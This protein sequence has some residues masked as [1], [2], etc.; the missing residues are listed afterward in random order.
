MNL[1]NFGEGLNHICDVSRLNSDSVIIDAGCNVGVFVET[2]RIHI[3]PKCEMKV[4]GI[5]PSK[6]N[7][8]FI[9]NKNLQNFTLLNSA[10]VGRGDVENVTM[11]EFIGELKAD[12][13]NRYH[14]W[15]NIYGHHKEKLNGR[16]VHINEY[17]VS[18][19]TIEDL[20][21][22]FDIK[23]IDYLKIDIEGAEYEVF[24]NLS[25][26]AADKIMQI[27]LEEHDLSK[28]QQ[29]KD[30]LESLGFIVQQFPLQEIYAYR[31][32]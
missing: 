7:C 11:T 31:E 2:L 8:G 5:E 13:T 27:S 20:I 30:H 1:F 6:K 28:N 4:I 32:V 24:E 26:E 23:Q 22:Q 3:D 15:N 29:V 19:I 12:G 25:Q 10:L 18:A 16:P 14:Q 9:N 21:D 17:S